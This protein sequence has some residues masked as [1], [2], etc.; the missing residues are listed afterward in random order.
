V[1]FCSPDQYGGTYAVEEEAEFLFSDS[2]SAQDTI[3]VYDELPGVSVFLSSWISEILH[4]Q[5]HIQDIPLGRHILLPKHLQPSTPGTASKTWS[6][7]RDYCD[8]GRGRTHLGGGPVGVGVSQHRAVLKPVLQ[9]GA[10]LDA[11][12]ESLTNL[13][14]NA[15]LDDIIHI[16]QL[17]PVV[18]PYFRFIPEL[19]QFVIKRRKSAPAPV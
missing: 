16:K 5:R 2:A 6:N 12:W 15:K 11:E 18:T 13:Y 1:L 10:D 4:M 9:S 3:R 19:P 17:K 8:S 7:S 14:K